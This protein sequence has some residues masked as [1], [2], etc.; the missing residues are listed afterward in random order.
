MCG[1]IDSDRYA[2]DRREEVHDRY[3]TGYE[4]WYLTDHDQY[5]TNDEF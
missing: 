5:N 2:S 1:P 3:T 4:F